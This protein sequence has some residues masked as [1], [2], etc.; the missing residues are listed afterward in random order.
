MGTWGVGGLGVVT[1]TYLGSLEF[2]K[3]APLAADVA[4]IVRTALDAPGDG[5]IGAGEEALGLEF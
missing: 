1:V 2:H 5:V 4:E 3:R